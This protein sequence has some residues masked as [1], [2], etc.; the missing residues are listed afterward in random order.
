MWGAARVG[1]YGISGKLLCDPSRSYLAA[2][3]TLTIWTWA[4]LLA[5]KQMLHLDCMEIPLM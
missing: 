1:L 3:Q 2:L 4:A 5:S